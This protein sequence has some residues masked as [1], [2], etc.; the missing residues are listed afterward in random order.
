MTRAEV[1]HLQRPPLLTRLY[2]PSLPRAQCWLYR[3]IPMA[4]GDVQTHAGG[5]L[6]QRDVPDLG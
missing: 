1:E 5:R 3:L 6:L 2:A 4:R